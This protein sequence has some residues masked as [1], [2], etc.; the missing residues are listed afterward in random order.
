MLNSTLVFAVLALLGI[1]TL[2]LTTLVLLSRRTPEPGRS[3]A[4]ADGTTTKATPVWWQVLI[5]LA[6]LA[7]AGLALYNV[8]RT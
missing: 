6:T 5:G 2:G 1:L 8:L 7:S 4:K 3:T